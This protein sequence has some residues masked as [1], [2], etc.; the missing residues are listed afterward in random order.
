M[1]GWCFQ[2]GHSGQALGSGAELFHVKS[3][4][5]DW[6]ENKWLAGWEV[7]WMFEMANSFS[8]TILCGHGAESLHFKICCISA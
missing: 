4:P 1:T 3:W 2:W 7:N 5:F 8:L 6:T